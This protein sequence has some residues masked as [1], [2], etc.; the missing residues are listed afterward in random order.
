MALF[1]NMLENYQTAR[2]ENVDEI[3]LPMTRSDIADY[4]GLSLEAVTRS[5]RLLEGTHILAF[6]NRRHVKII[7][8]PQ[9]EAIALLRETTRPAARQSGAD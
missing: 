6:R 7:D 9:L 2:G 5:F 4:V 3:Y 8:R 1:L